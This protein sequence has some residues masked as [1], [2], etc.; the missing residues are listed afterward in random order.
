M[1]YDRAVQRFIVQFDIPDDTD[2]VAFVVGEL[3]RVIAQ[4]QYR[5]V[6]DVQ[7]MQPDMRGTAPPERATGGFAPITSS[8]WGSGVQLH[9][10]SP[11]ATALIR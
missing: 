5:G 6:E 10:A 3:E 9:P 7:I 11:D 1:Y 8:T 4:V 2:S